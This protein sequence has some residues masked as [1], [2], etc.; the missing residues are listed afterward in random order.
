MIVSSVCFSLKCKAAFFGFSCIVLP[1]RFICHSAQCLSH[2]VLSDNA[3][4]FS[5]VIFN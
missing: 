4:P 2:M 1:S 5:F 3:I